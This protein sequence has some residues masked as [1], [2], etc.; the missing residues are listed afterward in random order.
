MGLAEILVAINI[1]LCVI[2]DNSNDNK[3]E[4][5][6]PKK[7]TKTITYT[8]KN[9]GFIMKAIDELQFK[10]RVDAR[11][12]SQYNMQL[13]PIKDDLRGIVQLPYRGNDYNHM[14]VESCEELQNLCSYA[15]WGAIGDKHTG[16][17]N[18]RAFHNI[19]TDCSCSW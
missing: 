2:V 12:K 14:N 15:M 17:F 5:N 1:I 3:R 11:K 6:K 18:S 7:P 19:M 4:L 16:T 10:D 9:D 8:L 13:Y